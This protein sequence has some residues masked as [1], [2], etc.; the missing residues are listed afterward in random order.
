MRGLDNAGPFWYIGCG[1]LAVMAGVTF[2]PRS[3]PKTNGHTEI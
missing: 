1:T 2:G 3:N